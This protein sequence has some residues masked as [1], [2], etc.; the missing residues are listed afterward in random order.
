MNKSPDIFRETGTTIA[1]TGIDEGI[2][3]T[4]VGTDA[5]ANVLDIDTEAITEI[6]NFIHKRD[7]G[8]Q[9]GIAC[10]LGHFGIFDTHKQNPVMVATEL[11]VKLSH[12]LTRTVGSHTN[13]DT[14]RLHKIFDRG[15]FFQ[16]L[17]VADDIKGNVCP[18]LVESLFECSMNLLCGTHRN[19]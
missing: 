9:H 7:F 10:V 11:F 1:A 2:T 15:A 16:K 19:G 6:G 18:A 4:A 3:N 14:V 13:H 12:N 5:K 17:R 8:G